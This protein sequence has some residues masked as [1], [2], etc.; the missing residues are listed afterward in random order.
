MRVLL[1]GA[2]GTIGSAIAAAL[3][4]RHEVI[5][6]SRHAGDH[7]VDITDR[8]SI[9]ALFAATGAVH[10]VVSAAGAV[11]FG[12][13]SRLSDDDFEFGLRSKLMGQANLV[14]TGMDHVLD[15]GS[16]TL[17][18]GLVARQPFP[19]GAMASMM[20]GAL[21]AFV[22]AAALEMPRGIRVNVVAPPWVK[23]TLERLGREPTGGLAAA[24]V[25]TAY[26]EAVEGTRNG[27]FIEVN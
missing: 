1:V 27:A 15:G 4:P 2:S 12:P 18:T 26:V 20:N 3:E 5:R 24:D 19:G 11:R 21:E 17:T 25:A 22:R 23:E 10:A 16:I 13:L 9:E 6:A 7:R 14:R 8:S